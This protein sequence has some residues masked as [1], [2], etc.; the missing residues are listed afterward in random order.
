MAARQLARRAGHP[1]SQWR[2]RAGFPPASLHHRPLSGQFY[3][4]GVSADA[5]LPG[6]LAQIGVEIGQG[7]VILERPAGG[8]QA[9][10]VLEI[11]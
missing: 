5:R 6:E 4:P 9:A 1:R 10:G 7:A 2:V 11:V 8:D 3:P